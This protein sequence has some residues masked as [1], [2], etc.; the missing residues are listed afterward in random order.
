VDYL[1]AALLTG[2][3]AG[4]IL[5]LST[6]GVAW[7]WRSW[8]TAIAAIGF[9]ALAGAG[10]LRQRKA[11][12]PILPLRLFRVRTFALVSLTGFLL[13]VVM[14]TGI[15]Y[16][17]QYLQVVHGVD[18]TSSGL[19]MLPQ[20][21]AMILTTFVVG[22]LIV[23]SG[24][25]KV[26]PVVGCVLLIAGPLLIASLLLV[27][28]FSATTQL[29]ALGAAMVL[30]GVGI[31]MAQQVLVLIAQESAGPNELG[32][33]TSAATFLRTLGGAVGVAAFGAV[34]SVR[35]HV[36]LGRRLSALGL[37]ESGE[38]DRLLGTPG[39]IG[40]LSA[41]LVAAVRE[42]Y[43]AALGV[44]FLCVVPAAV[45]ALLAVAHCEELPL[46]TSQHEIPG[47]S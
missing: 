12:D 11:P 21:G 37:S 15:I 19:L 44:V 7:P 39:E 36:E 2:A 41:P 5:L 40:R 14:F 27:F 47:G 28:R 6:S 10:V 20:I 17:P 45:L 3:A 33:A 42:S 23:R 29:I 26:F 34:I 46:Q 1:G 38:P 43:A 30:L 8:P 16:L 9:V 31:G 32:V 24:R 22:H 4:L 25:W 35:L 13:G 18:A